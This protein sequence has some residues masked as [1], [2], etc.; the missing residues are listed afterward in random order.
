[1]TCFRYLFFLFFIFIAGC[2]SSQNSFPPFDPLNSD[3]KK[4]DALEK[5][6]KTQTAFKEVK[7]ILE[8][9]R[10]SQNYPQIVKSLLKIISYQ[11]I[12]D[13]DAEV[14]II[15]ALEK[16]IETAQY[17]LKPVLQS[18]LAQ[19]YW[20]Y[21]DEYGDQT[22]EDDAINYILSL[23]QASLKE[24]KKLK[25]TPLG[26]YDEILLKHEGSKKLRPTLFD[27]LAHR[28]LDFY[29]EITAED[30]PDGFDPNWEASLLLQNLIHFHLRDSSPEALV[31]LELKKLKFMWET[32]EGNKR[33]EWYPQSLKNLLKQYKHHPVSAS[34][35]FELAYFYVEEL[36]HA[37][38]GRWALKEA[39]DFCV[40]AITLYP[41]EFGS[42]NCQALQKE[43]LSSSVSF[44]IEGATLPN[45]PF[46]ALVKYK[47]APEIYVRIVS[48]SDLIQRNIESQP[49][50]KRKDLLLALPVVKEWK[51]TLPP[52]QDYHLHSV[53]I[54][55]PP[56]EKGHY[57]VLAS[58]DKGFDSSKNVI[59]TQGIWITN[60]SYIYRINRDDSYTFSI[61]DR[62]TGASIVGVKGTVWI[63][64]YNS[65]SK[66]EEWLSVQTYT[67]DAFG[68][69]VVS[70][71]MG[72]RD[73]NL[74]LENGPD[75]F[76][77]QNE[78][79]QRAVFDKPQLPEWKSLVFTD[80]SIYR[81][82]QPIYFKIVTYQS[83]EGEKE[84][85]AGKPITVT[86]EDSRYQTVA[87]LKLVTNKFG[88]VSGSFIAPTGLNGEYKISSLWGE[89]WVR[90]EEYKRP[91]FEV[92]F[93]PI[94]GLTKPN[95]FVEV[96]GSAMGFSGIKMGGSKVSYQVSKQ[97]EGVYFKDRHGIFVFD[98]GYGS[99]EKV[100]SGT[101]FVDAEGKFTVKFKALPENK[102]K[103]EEYP[104]STYLVTVDI[105]DPSGETRSQTTEFK[106][107]DLDLNIKVDLPDSVDRENLQEWKIETTNL[108]GA[109][110][111]SQGTFLV[112]QLKEPT[113]LIKKR[114][115]EE[116]NQNK[117]LAETFVKE[118]KI[119]EGDFNTAES[120]TLS[121][122]QMAKW[123]EGRYL[124]EFR[125]KDKNGNLITTSKEFILYSSQTKASP[126]FDYAWFASQ[127]DRYEVGDSSS[128]FIGSAA[129]DIHFFYT[130]V[131]NNEVMKKV[132]GK[133]NKEKKEIQIPILENYRGGIFIQM[134]FVKDNRFYSY[135][136]LIDVP[137]SQKE[138]KLEFSTFR[139]KLL[140][141]QKEEWRMNVSGKQGEKVIAE[142]VATLYDAS[143]DAFNPHFWGYLLYPF[144]HNYEGW[145]GKGS[146]DKLASSSFYPKREEDDLY[147][148][149]R[150]YDEL[151]WYADDPLPGMYFLQN[152]ASNGTSI[153]E[154]NGHT[155]PPDP[156]MRNGMIQMDGDDGTV[157]YFDQEVEKKLP[158]YQKA[159]TSVDI[160]KDLK[161]TAFFFPHLLTNEEGEMIISFTIPEA[162]TRWKFMGWAHTPDM[163]Y[164]FLTDITVT[165]KKLMVLPHPPRFLREG[166]KIH[167]STKIANLSDEELKGEVWLELFDAQTMKSRNDLLVNKTPL[168]FS[169]NK[170]ETKALKWE[171]MIPEDLEGITYR[172][173]AKAGEFSDGEESILPVLSNR[174]LV[175]ETLPFSVNGGETQNFTFKKLIESNASKTLT[176]YRLTLESVGNPIW[177]A[178]QSLP[179]LMEFPH[180][181]SEQIFSRFYANVLGEHIL[182]S[183]PEIQKVFNEWG[184]EGEL[185][186]S[187]WSLDAKK[188]SEQKKLMATLFNAKQLQ[189]EKKDILDKL[190]KMQSGSGAWPWFKG[191]GDS[192]TVTAHILAGLGHLNKLK[193]LSL[194]Q[195][196]ISFMIDPAIAY[197]D[198]KIFEDYQLQLKLKDKELIP[199]FTLV[200]LLYARSF[201]PHPIDKKKMIAFNYWQEQLLEKWTKQDLYTKAMTALVLFRSDHFEGAQKIITAFK[202]NAVLDESQGMHWKANRLGVYWNES[203]IETQALVIEAFSEITEDIKSIDAMKN[204]LL[205]QKRAQSWKSTKAT[206]EAIYALLMQGT[207]WMASDSAVSI[208]VGGE[209]LDLGKIKNSQAEIK[210]GYFKKTWEPSEIKGAL[211]E[212]QVTNN[213]LAPTWGSLYWQYFENLDQITSSQSSLNLKKQI[214]FH[215]GSK[216][217][218]VTPKTKLKLGDK[219]TIQLTLSTDQD[220]TYIHL[221]D[222]RASG[223]EPVDVIS[224]YHYQGKIGYYQVTKD[225]ST[226]FF[227]EN[228]PRGVY[229]ISYDLWVSHLGDFSTG[230]AT[231]ESMYAPEFT[232]HSKGIRIEVH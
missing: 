94:T 62:E 63:K 52:A 186:E 161:E 110:T 33:L 225:V 111:P 213:N 165:Q 116:P 230:I 189:R 35:L 154:S 56:L 99:Q 160:R 7:E 39:N 147:I 172:V 66:K 148:Q 158:S 1:M 118:K 114:Y 71:K 61:L 107:G 10:T 175:T 184:K 150:E 174:I 73:F 18:I 105:T 77:A 120:K 15:K 119:F 22:E 199:S 34:I 156:R 138:L 222:L 181:C 221:K 47:G 45:Q 173:I 124:L 191:M 11:S 131:H 223:L 224:G 24:E 226:H 157:K 83:L 152:K 180:E 126:I 43:Y 188:E 183:N 28:A 143:L 32:M 53:E 200:H 54:D 211:G 21:Y 60:L 5:E 113:Q 219:I 205:R 76:F 145:V 92:I 220:L 2:Q 101:T 51:V 65:K 208:L 197:V 128:F 26:I 67:S 193:V 13:E 91:K 16:E 169:L 103:K 171:L 9:A 72:S 117:N 177:V 57:F 30:F 141:G 214:F 232:A 97:H 229:S 185:K 201:F 48:S 102:K 78:F 140:P 217:I 84:I 142:M 69:L 218:L 204:W 212:L 203:P 194:D 12:L 19:Y 115:W 228:L 162:L 55:M 41:K 38:Q 198:S 179:Y 85:V 187:P 44:E 206:T 122:N 144:Y 182:K 108:N 74:A 17:P 4:I 207:S 75:K 68:E 129:S 195:K 81:P 133:L 163:K 190:Q 155:P 86:L 216:L 98:S 136:K 6:E 159:I 109:L 3:W 104:V 46:L 146:F 112:Y 125:A 89:E 135:E 121:I 80:R 40:Q 192:P 50:E 29:M 137:W 49:W 134:A 58:P 167:F 178:I 123:E 31:D 25:E 64:N 196:E 153:G 36:N 90:V 164:G 23:Y 215:E 37:T 227:I 231:F 82:G 130:V 168:S 209:K 42:K 14:N 96:T 27:F 106:V 59:V 88:S 79:Y 127:G 8:T 210:T 202:E 95:Q 93:N 100:T 176:H 20:G 87:D 170:E 139:D 166:D 149:E 132:E 151:V 70:S